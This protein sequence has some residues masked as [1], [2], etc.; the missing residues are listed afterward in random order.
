MQRA[1][2]SNTFIIEKSVKYICKY[3]TINT[4][5]QGILYIRS[6]LFSAKLLPL[7]DFVQE[8]PENRLSE[9]IG[10]TVCHIVSDEGFYD[11]LSE[12]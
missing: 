3:N 8:L 11:S 5:F 2:L 7:L 1:G 10:Q 9:V 4:S 12:R 6:K